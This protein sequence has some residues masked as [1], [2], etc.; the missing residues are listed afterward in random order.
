VFAVVCDGMGGLSEGKTA[1]LTV[2]EK[3]KELYFSKENDIDYPDFFLNSVD[4]LDESV[5]NLRNE[6]GDKIKTGTTI[7]AIAI[8]KD[9]LFW[10]S[11]GDS[12]LYIIRGNEIVRATRD[13]NYFLSLNQ[14]L[15][16]GTITQKQ[17]D[18]EAS[19][20]DTLISF[21]GM[22]GIDL[23]DINK[24]PLKLSSGDIMLLTSDGLY[25]I[26]KDDEILNSVKNE[27]VEGALETLM[28]NLITKNKTSQDNTTCILIKYL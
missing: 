20:G 2:V 18:D 26:L 11:V 27:N 13:H 19:K 17:Y 25:K 21:I 1:S 5:F 7:V 4:I 16:S 24:E 14:S 9:C 6:F 15:K 12:R 8:E 10:F 22:G 28:K 23:M 3:I